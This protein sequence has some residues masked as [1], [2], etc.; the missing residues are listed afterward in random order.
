MVVELNTAA[1]NRHQLSIHGVDVDGT[2]VTFLRTVKLV[3]NRRVAQV[4]P[5]QFSL[6]EQSEPGVDLAMELEFMGHYGEP[7]LDIVHHVFDSQA[8]RTLYLLDYNPASGVWEVD[9]QD[10][11]SDREDTVG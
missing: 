6:R 1:D 7:N 5:F 10:V 3:N 4:E 8:T 11:T 9:K 2:P